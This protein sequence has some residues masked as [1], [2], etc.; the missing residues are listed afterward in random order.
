M[1]NQQQLPVICFQVQPMRPSPQFRQ[2][3][4]PTGYWIPPKPRESNVLLPGLTTNNWY[5]YDGTQVQQ[6][7]PPPEQSR[8]LY[9]QH[10]MYYEEGHFWIV[11]GDASTHQ[12][13][14]GKDNLRLNPQ[15]YGFNDTEA[16]SD[17]NSDSDEADSSDSDDE[18]AITGTWEHLRFNHINLQS[19]A[20]F[21]AQYR[22][23]I[24]QDLNQAWV[25]QILPHLY[26]EPQQ[27][28]QPQPAGGLL[29]D[30]SILI[31]LVA[32][33]VPESRV[34]NALLQSMQHRYVP[35]QGLGS[36]GQGWTPRRG[37][38]VSVYSLIDPQTANTS[39]PTLHPRSA[40]ATLQ[41][42]ERGRG[43]YGKFFP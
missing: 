5:R 28:P 38:V 10:S 42:F 2:Q 22:C 31:A 34:H 30:L 13:G 20:R 19:Y 36:N 25:N 35:H 9:S 6:M 27:P 7:Q 29:G 11:K 23:L 21:E 18:G 43:P 14:D 40:P 15:S 33:S 17:S 8:R 37:V 41:R 39:R 3:F 32:F 16:D 4:G 12:V 24:V 1:A 26:R